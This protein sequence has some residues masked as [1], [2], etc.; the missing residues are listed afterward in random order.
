MDRFIDFDSDEIALVNGK[1]QVSYR[2][3]FVRCQKK[4]GDLKSLGAEKGSIV[5]VEISNSI[6]FV[7]Y[8][9]TCAIF[10][11]C[12]VPINDL[13]SDDEKKYIIDDCNPAF[14]VKQGEISVNDATRKV[15]SDIYLICY[16]SG[17]TGS[18]KG[19]CHSLEALVANVRSFNS[20]AG[21]NSN[22]IMY[23]VL[24]MGYM[25]GFLNTILSP[26]CAHG[27]VVIGEQFSARSIINFWPVALENKCNTI[28]LTP[29]ILSYLTKITRSESI[30]S[31]VRDSFSLLLIGTAPLLAPV[32]DAFEKK[33]NLKCTESY[34]MTEVLLVSANI[35][36]AD[37]S[38]GQ[39]IDLAE[40]ENESGELKIR[41]PNLFLGYY[42]QGKMSEAVAKGEYFCT[43]DLFSCDDKGNLY[44]EGRKK[45]LIIKGGKNISAKYIE[46]V[47]VSHE[48]IIDAAVIGIPHSF[49]GEEIVAVIVSEGSLTEKAVF[50]YCSLFLSRDLLPSQVVFV[51]DFPRSST[52]KINKSMLKEI[53]L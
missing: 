53:Y 7:V 30:I 48:E 11:Y 47:L 24:P 42:H 12:I 9:I 26:L 45:D 2:E 6:E 52:G 46:E 21:I 49:W 31:K 38:V 41:T 34:G 22:T 27:K 16:T 51:K 17:T 1:E 3:L 25:A 14:I 40:I 35:L 5:S 44:I 50:N 13:L 33:F 10:D 29:T 23:H 37:S 43:G 15:D 36:H 4:G 19:V 20:L 8:Y 28:W 39:L 18:P 32:R